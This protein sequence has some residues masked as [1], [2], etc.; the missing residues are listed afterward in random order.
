V[1]LLVGRLVG[2]L[3]GGKHVKVNDLS[4]NGKMDTSPF[5][6]SRSLR[7]APSWFGCLDCWAGSNDY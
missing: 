4:L 2:R 6:P 3:G 5:A 7:R 1:G